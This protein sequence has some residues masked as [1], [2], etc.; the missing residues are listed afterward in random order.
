MADMKKVI[1]KALNH[2]EYIRD[3]KQV[4]MDAV[5][6]NALMLSAKTDDYRLDERLARAQEIYANYKINEQDFKNFKAISDGIYFMLSD[7]TNHFEDYLGTIYMEIE[8]GN[9]NSGQYFTPYNISKFM[10]MITLGEKPTGE[11]VFTLNEPCC[12]SGG[13]V[14][15]TA[16]VWTE[17]GFN[18]TNNALVIANDIDRNCVLMS[19]LQ[20]SF[21]GMPAVIKHQDTLTQ[22]TWDRFITPAFLLQYPKFK[23]VYDGLSKQPEL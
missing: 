19:Y 4:F 1:L 7:M 11:K 3:K 23:R 10:A 18:Y 6:F 13:M 20:I 2:F 16:D 9:K 5:E 15:A 14:I 17:Q 21:T 22:K 12:G 8:A